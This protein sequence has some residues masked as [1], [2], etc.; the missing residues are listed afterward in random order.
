MKSTVAILSLI[1][2]LLAPQLRAG[3]SPKKPGPEH[4]K[5]EMLIGKWK[6]EDYTY[7]NPF[8]Q[9]PG[10]GTAQSDAQFIHG[11]FF[12]IE[13]AKG[14]NPGGRYS[15]T[16][17]TYFDADQTTYSIFGC[18]SDGWAGGLPVTIEGRTITACWEQ[19]A[20]EKKYK[21]KAVTVYATN[22]RSL[23]YEHSYSEDGV[24]WKPLL[25]G[26]GRKVGKAK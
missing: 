26:T 11:G 20:G 7:P 2:S 23:T 17:I 19:Q 15:G 16:V 21:L 24:T 3:D 4:K 12:V 14:R 5:L 22:G 25:K 8:G 9:S 10:K 18:A 6:H 13:H 1:V